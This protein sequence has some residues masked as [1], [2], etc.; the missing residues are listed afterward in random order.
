[1]PCTG[2]ITPFYVDV[3]NAGTIGLVLNIRRVKIVPLAGSEDELCWGGT[4]GMG[5]ACYSYGL[6]A[7]LDVFETSN[8]PTV[9]AGTKGQIQAYHKANGYYGTV[10]YRYIVFDTLTMTNLDSVDAIFTS[11]AGLETFN[12]AEITVYPNPTENDLTVNVDNADQNTSIVIYDI[13]GKVVFASALII[14]QNNLE[15]SRLQAG[16]YIYTIRNSEAVLRN[17]K[18]I[19]Q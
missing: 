16:T 17:D 6:I 14:G 1:M 11:A 5:G 9:D 10:Q 3:E 2:N 13:N 19:I 4:G 7:P 15:L 8:N 18:L 12:D